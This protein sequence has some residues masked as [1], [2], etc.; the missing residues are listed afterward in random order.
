MAVEK[1][2][3]L[4]RRSQPIGVHKRMARCRKD[5]NIVHADRFEVVGNPPGTS[6]DVG[7]VFQVRADTWNRKKRL[8]LVEVTI[9][10]RIDVL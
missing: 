7:P 9:L 5:L 6:L 10:V 2:G 4:P 8:K 1:Q 3:R